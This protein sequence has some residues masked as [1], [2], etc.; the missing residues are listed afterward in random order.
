[1]RLTTSTAAGYPLA[2]CLRVGVVTLQ[3][4]SLYNGSAFQIG[5]MLGLVNHVAGSVL[6]AP[7]LGLRIMRVFP[8]F[9]ARPASRPLLIEA[10]HRPLILWVDALLCR[11][12]LHIL[13]I[14]LLRYYD[15]PECADS[16]WL[17]SRSNRSPNADPEKARAL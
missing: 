12:F 3:N 13:P 7:H 6:G 14:G 11:Q 1:M 16:H 9:I 17:R 8:F 2:Q 10:A 4:L 15:A 5:H